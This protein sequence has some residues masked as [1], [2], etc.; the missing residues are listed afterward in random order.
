M[1]AEFI[2]TTKKPEILD[3]E[4]TIRTFEG[5]Y[6][7]VFDPNFELINI[8]DIAHS[9]SMQC[10]FNGHTKKFYSVAQHSVWVAERVPLKDRMAALL[11]D[12]SEAYLCDI[13][14]PIKRHFTQYHGIE[15]G[16]MI[17]IA[18]RFKFEYPFPP[19]VKEFDRAALVWEWDNKVLANNFPEDN[20]SPEEAEKRFLEFFYNL[21]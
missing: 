2:A 8:H 15:D 5:I 14:S 19:S 21:V 18:K 1:Q 3:T 10:R 4:R 12:G 16:V 13:P 6:F 11:H 20:W 17:A 7:D 9:L